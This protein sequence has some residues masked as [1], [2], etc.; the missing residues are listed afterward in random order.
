MRRSGLPTKW[1]HR[2]L[3]GFVTQ[4]RL[5]EEYAQ[6]LDKSGD[7]SKEWMALDRRRPFFVVHH[8]VEASC[9][10]FLPS[11]DSA[12]ERRRDE[13]A[14]PSQSDAMFGNMTR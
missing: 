9:R 6:I 10:K 1:P 14:P 3:N 5:A 4:R 8:D 11:L 13:C 7:L 12:E 2:G